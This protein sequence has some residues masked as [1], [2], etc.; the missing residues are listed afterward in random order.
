LKSKFP[1]WNEK[2]VRV[3]VPIVFFFIGILL[4]PTAFKETIEKNKE[5]TERKESSE[6]RKEQ[7]SK[8]LKEQEA[9]SPTPK[10]DIKISARALHA[11][12]EAN[13]VAA[14]NQYKGKIL[15][16]TGTV[17]DIAKDFLDKPYV[18]LNVG[19][20]FQSVHCYFSGKENNIL[21][22]LKKN[23]RVTIIG[24]CDGFVMLSVMMKNCEVWEE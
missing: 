19:T 13:E 1:L 21:A 23:Q 5:T 24:K 7:N 14:D 22:Q 11:A 4:F 9:S 3:I 20:F 8:P 16:V 12:Y 2:Y 15:A 17:E 10:W 6:P 18:T